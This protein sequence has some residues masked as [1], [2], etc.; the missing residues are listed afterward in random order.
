MRSGGAVGHVVRCGSYR[1]SC[2]GLFRG[3]RPALRP[4]A[5]RRAEVLIVLN[6]LIQFAAAGVLAGV[7]AG[8]FG[9]GGGLVLVPALFVMLVNRVPAENLT[10]YVIATSL[11]AIVFSAASSAFCHWRRG[12]VDT[13]QWLRL[14]PALIAGSAAG[15]FG[16]AY[17]SRALLLGYVAVLQVVMCVY[18]VRKTFFASTLTASGSPSRVV[19]SAIGTLCVA[20]GI[21]IGALTVPYLRRHNLAPHVAVG[22]AAALGIPVAIVGTAVL[23]ISGF[24]LTGVAP[25]TVGF[26]CL[27][28]LAGLAPGV[29]LGAQAGA[30]AAHR[31]SPRVLMSLFCLFLAIVSLRSIAVLVT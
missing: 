8:M 20:A 24:A 29:V 25:W 10:Q 16:A 19:I 23:V 22:T 2:D 5:N 26:V 11:A 1:L 4:S 27:P 14:I 21:G 9:V 28:A 6:T 3:G 7:T 18:L 30:A 13:H 12:A 15:A 17:A 31:C